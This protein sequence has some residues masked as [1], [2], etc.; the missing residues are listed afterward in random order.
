MKFFKYLVQDSTNNKGNIK[1]L[2]I[3]FLF[4]LAQKIQSKKILKYLLFFYLAFYRFFIEW[5]LGVELPWKVTAGKGLIIHH[6]QS[7]VVH[8]QV[9]L[10]NNCLL[11]HCT[12]IGRKQLPDGSYGLSPNIGNNVDI[13]A[14]SCILG[15]IKIGNNV[16]IGAGSV[17]TKDVPD[18][19]IVV[20]NPAQIL[21]YI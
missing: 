5:I 6:G 19:C 17:V 15:N 11:R 20:G 2:F 3:L 21:R 8:Y 7:L 18:N 10:G 4:R 16:I 13:G 1:G 9:V 14:N 12:T